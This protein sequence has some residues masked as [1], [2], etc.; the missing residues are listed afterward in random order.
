MSNY[1][2][3]KDGKPTGPFDESEVLRQVAAGVLSATDLCWREGMGNWEPIAGVLAV[4]SAQSSPPPILG[5]PPNAVEKSPLFLHIPI[6]RL[7]LMSILS[8]SL[9]EAYWIYRNWRYVRERDNLDIRPFWRGMF[10]VFYCH[11]LL[12][13]IHGDAEARSVQMP[14]FSPGD[15]AT[16]WVLLMI[17]A[18]VVSR[19][20]GI[21]A[22][23]IAAL[24]PSFLCLVPVQ[25]YV[26]AVS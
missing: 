2:I 18:N 24:I 4:S 6:S 21:V 10:G 11:S 22:S 12:R 19:A 13:R 26:N 3:A 9:Y 25:N 23:I 5:T 8:F 15:L 14:S 17:F 1:F 16:G 7:I 20:P